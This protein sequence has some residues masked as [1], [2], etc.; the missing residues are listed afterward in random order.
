MCEKV[1]LWV[2]RTVGLAQVLVIALAF[3][4]WRELG[5][6]ELVALA[7]L[8]TYPHAAAAIE[9]LVS[10]YGFLVGCLFGMLIPV[11]IAALAQRKKWRAGSRVLQAHWL[12]IILLPAIGLALAAFYAA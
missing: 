3:W 6:W 1:A 5:A 10:R 2:L 7:D 8:R 12:A 9:T 4:T 11:I